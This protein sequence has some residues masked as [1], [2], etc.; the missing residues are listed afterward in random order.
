S[1]VAYLHFL[2]QAHVL[3]R[4]RRLVGEGVEQ[5]HL[6]IGE[7]AHISAPDDNRPGRFAHTEQRSGQD[8]TVTE[9]LG[10]D[11]ALAV[12]VGLGLHIRD[13]DRASVKD[14]SPGWRLPNQGA[15]LAD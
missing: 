1:L 15:S 5:G 11:T 9:A 12:L 6:P 3:D 2:E 10:A 14:G 8:R 4:D 13:V 7:R